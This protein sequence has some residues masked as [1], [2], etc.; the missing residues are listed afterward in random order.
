MPA[1]PENEAAENAPQQG[2]VGSLAGD[3][4]RVSR[5]PQTNGRV[6]GNRRV[7]PR[8][9]RE[10]VR[11]IQ[12]LL[13]KESL[14]ALN[15][16]SEFSDDAAFQGFLQANLPQN[17]EETRCRYA[18][19]LMRWFFPDGVRGLAATAWAAYQDLS[20]AEEILRYVYLREEPMMGSAVAD[21]LFPIAENAAIPQSYLTN[22]LLARFGETTPAKSIKRVKANLRKL[23]LLS[24]EKG[25][26]DTLRPMTPSPTAF[27]LVLHHIFARH[28]AGGVEFRT[29][30]ENP[31]WKY[32]GFKSEDQLRALLKS[33]MVKSIIAKY[34]VADRI[35]SISF[36]H[37]FDSFV[38]ARMRP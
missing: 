8:M 18:Q 17:S 14:F 31:F 11:G 9:A 22:F 3:D 19:N 34:V 28:E 25:N 6:G 16:I 24:K 12:D 26:K 23:G 27:F 15:H 13:W 20:L 1:K 10:D 21:A 29:M 7:S 5:P 38:T 4:A 2:L 37:T 30:L 32:L 35:E 36:R 33:G